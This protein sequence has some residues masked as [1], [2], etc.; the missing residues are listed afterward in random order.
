MPGAVGGAFIIDYLGPKNTMVRSFSPL[1]P[2][3]MRAQIAGLLLQAL[4]GFIMS[5]CYKALSKHIG[6]FAVMYGIF[7]TFGELGA[8]VCCLLPIGGWLTV[9]YRYG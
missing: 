7:L 2:L 9:V 5:G 4:F 8:S 1:A 3:L 6:G